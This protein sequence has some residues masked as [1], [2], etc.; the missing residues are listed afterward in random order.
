MSN[1]GLTV[2][3][4]GIL[5]CVFS[6]PGQNPAPEPAFLKYIVCVSSTGLWFKRPP[7]H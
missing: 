7:E 2:F 5:N 3:W 1:A 6:E 4:S